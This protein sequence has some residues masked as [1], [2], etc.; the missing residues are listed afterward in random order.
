MCSEVYEGI[1]KA[2][3]KN[4]TQIYKTV[5]PV[6]ADNIENV[7]DYKQDSTPQNVE[8]LDNVKG[9]LVDYPYRF[10]INSLIGVVPMPKIFI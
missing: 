3:A 4:N 9:V 6:I 10:L 1:W 8:L 5:F 7:E 2:T